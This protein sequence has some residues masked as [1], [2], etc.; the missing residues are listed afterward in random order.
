MDEA[1]EAQSGMTY[2]TEPHL[3]DYVRV[4]YTRRWTIVLVVVPVIMIT[5]LALVTTR[6]EYRS[7]CRVLLQPTRNSVMSYKEVYDPSLG[8][9]AGGAMLTRQ[10]S[11]RNTA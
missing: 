5:L 9:A 6:K 1:T 7:T 10:F 2:Q 4:L 3:R 8:A 11:R